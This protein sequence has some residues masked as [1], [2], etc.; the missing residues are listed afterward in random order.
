MTPLPPTTARVIANGPGTP[1]CGGLYC[2]RTA[3]GAMS[4]SGTK[5]TAGFWIAVLIREGAQLLV[6]ALLLPVVVWWA[7][8]SAPGLLPVGFHV[9]CQVSGLMSAVFFAP[10]LS[11]GDW[12]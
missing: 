4:E 9:R 11:G 3:P 12:I 10:P 7:V 6:P 8:R 2:P 1:E 5:S